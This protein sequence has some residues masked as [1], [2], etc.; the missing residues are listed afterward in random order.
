MQAGNYTVAEAINALTENEAISIASL[1]VNGKQ[2]VR[3]IVSE[4]TQMV[5][6]HTPCAK[7]KRPIN[8]WRNYNQRRTSSMSRPTSWTASALLCETLQ[9]LSISCKWSSSHWRRNANVW[10]VECWKSTS[11]SNT[12]FRISWIP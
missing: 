1:T 11:G 6:A 12:C 5:E 7:P 9:A 8:F 2:A 10:P 3:D 4:L